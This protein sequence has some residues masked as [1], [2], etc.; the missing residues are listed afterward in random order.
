MMIR[1]NARNAIMITATAR[2]FI[3]LAFILNKCSLDLI[4]NSSINKTPELN[5]ALLIS[6]ISSIFQN[7]KF[8]TTVGLVFSG[9]TLNAVATFVKQ[10]GFSVSLCHH[11]VSGYAPAY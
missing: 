5:Q 2:I 9:R 8:S 7:F 6:F 4:I 3:L 11:S 10:L 1:I